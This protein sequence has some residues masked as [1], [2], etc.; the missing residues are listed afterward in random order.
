MGEVLIEIRKK[1]SIQEENQKELILKAG[2][3][4]ALELLISEGWRPKDCCCKEQSDDF[5]Y[6]WTLKRFPRGNNDVSSRS[7]V[8]EE[9]KDEPYYTVPSP[10]IPFPYITNAPVINN[11][12]CGGLNQGNQN[13]LKPSEDLSSKVLEDS[14]EKDLKKDTLIKR[15]LPWEVEIGAGFSKGPVG[16]L[17]FGNNRAEAGGLFIW[18]RKDKIANNLVDLVLKTKEKDFVFRYGIFYHNEVSPQKWDIPS[19]ETKTVSAGGVSTTISS[20]RKVEVEQWN[21]RK[22]N[23]GPVLGIE[24]NFEGIKTFLDLMPG[25]ALQKGTDEKDFSLNARIGLGYLI[26]PK[27][28]L[29]VNYAVINKQLCPSFSVR[30]VPGLEKTTVNN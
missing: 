8:V 2:K 21:I 11:Y 22:Q 16:S 29:G 15:V 4:D 14:S 9:K 12:C 5:T 18:N 3:A 25:I 23:I 28:F 27:T 19:V 24:A 20:T 7:L 13:D 26:T 17:R 10:Q 6:S 30:F 1:D